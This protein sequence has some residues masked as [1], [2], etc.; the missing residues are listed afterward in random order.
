MDEQLHAI[1]SD[2]AEDIARLQLPAVELK[3]A[4]ALNAIAMNAETVGINQQPA[5]FLQLV[6]RQSRQRAE[7]LQD[8]SRQGLRT[9]AIVTHDQRLD[10][11]SVLGKLAEICFFEFHQ[12][13]RLLRRPTQILLQKRRE[14]TPPQFAEVALVMIELEKISRANV[15]GAA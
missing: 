5:L 3:N 12:P 6:E 2:I 4:L 10:H 11:C 15:I 8:I 7:C 9:A 1:N 13:L 14:V